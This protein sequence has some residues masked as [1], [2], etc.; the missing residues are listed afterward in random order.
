MISDLFCYHDG[1]SSIQASLVPCERVFSSSTET[2][3]K[4]WNQIRPILMGVL[5]LLKFHLKQE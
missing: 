1:L 4:K 5:Q 3:T 2:D